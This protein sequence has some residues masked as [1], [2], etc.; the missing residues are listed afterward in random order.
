EV[1]ISVNLVSPLGIGNY[2]GYC[3][4]RNSANVSFGEIIWVDIVTVSTNDNSQFV[5]DITVPDGTDFQ[6]NTSF[7]KIWRIRNTGTST[8]DSSYKL[9][10]QSGDQMSGPNEASLP[11]SVNPGEEVDIS[12]NLVSPNNIGHYRGY[13]KMSNTQ[14]YV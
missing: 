10:F 13:W 4:M 9:E 7:N 3:K 14:G 11:H 1:D 12:V 2:R 5:A 8:W 6:P